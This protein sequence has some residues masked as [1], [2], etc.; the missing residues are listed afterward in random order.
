[1]PHRH[2]LTAKRKPKCEFRIEPT[3]SS[4]STPCDRNSARAQ[5]KRCRNEPNPKTRASRFFSLPL[6]AL[7]FLLSAFCFPLFAS[8]FSAVHPR[9]QLPK[10]DPGSSTKKR[11]QNKTK[12]R[13]RACHARCTR[14]RP[15]C[16]SLPTVTLWARRCRNQSSRQPSPFACG[17][18][19]GSRQLRRRKA[20]RRTIALDAGRRCKP[21]RA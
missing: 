15:A 21:E 10:G 9:F 6:S 18:R 8:A 12:L 14:R 4:F 20:R 16:P 5:Q 1:M 7:R 17:P 19:P 11:W 3:Q 2:S 13:D